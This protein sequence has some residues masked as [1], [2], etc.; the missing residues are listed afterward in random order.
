M[1]EFDCSLLCSSQLT[2]MFAGLLGSAAASPPSGPRRGRGRGRGGHRGRGG[3][4]AARGGR[5]RRRNSQHSSEMDRHESA[6]SNPICKFF[7]QGRCNKGAECKWRH[8]I[9]KDH[10]SNEVG[11]FGG[12]V[13]DVE[14]AGHARGSITD[15]VE[16][17][18]MQ[19][20]VANTTL[21]AAVAMTH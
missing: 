1:F 14:A 4:G 15:V 10:F 17:I 2:P 12:L 7:Q 19:A 6:E 9:D 5:G 21:K 11:L 3:R 13:G 18:M 8:E 20:E 16:L